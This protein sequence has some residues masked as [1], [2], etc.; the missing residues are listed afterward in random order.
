MAR[1]LGD[2]LSPSRSLIHEKGAGLSFLAVNGASVCNQ[3]S[4]VSATLWFC[5]VTLDPLEG[6]YADETKYTRMRL[7]SPCAGQEQ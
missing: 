3:L 5:Q 6:S 7:V 1:Q 4:L 2:T